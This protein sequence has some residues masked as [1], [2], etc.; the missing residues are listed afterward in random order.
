MARPLRLAFP[1]G[2]YHVMSRGNAKQAI[3]RDDADR[4]RF[5]NALGAVVD[6]TNLLCHAY[7][8]MDNHYHL[9]LE[10]PDG[11]ISMAM[12]QLNGRYAQ[13][14][15]RRHE[16]VGHLFQGRFMS[17]L[18]EKDG[19]LLTVVRYISLNPV[20]ASLVQNPEDWTW[21]SYRAHCGLT[22]V[23]RFLAVDSV[24]SQ[25]ATRDRRLAQDR[26]VRMIRATERD[27]EPGMDGSAI[28]GSD[29]F[30]MR[31]QA[32]LTEAAALSD[33][34]RRHRIAG[35]PPLSEIL[36]AS[37]DR[38]ARARRVREAY[39]RHGYRMAEI[40]RHL[41]LHPMTVSRD[42]RRGARMLES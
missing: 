2:L 24:L 25:F 16:R 32:A 41:G 18:V 8:L 37:D 19:Y 12:R 31:F 34:D 40:A 4:V 6:E 36:Q 15:N 20:R 1:G 39:V 35:R 22:E 17:K 28:L 14:F 23:P 27:G 3:Y 7:C 38:T 33:I 9:L 29:E 26:F 10:T 5:L 11:N 21:S 30:V 13:G 42:L